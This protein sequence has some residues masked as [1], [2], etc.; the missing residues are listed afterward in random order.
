MSTSYTFQS[1]SVTLEKGAYR[2]RAPRSTRARPVSFTFSQ[3]ATS[4]KQPSLHSPN[5]KLVVLV[6]VL[7]FA[8][9]MCFFIAYY[10]FMTRFAPSFTCSLPVDNVPK[11][12]P[13]LPVAHDSDAQSKYLAYF[14]YVTQSTQPYSACLLVPP[15][16]LGKAIRYISLK[17][18]IILL[19]SALRSGLRAACWYL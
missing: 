13:F 4:A 15:P 19:H 3:G 18:S 9:V 7:A 1:P 10:L 11:A 8:S 12:N 6:C 14:P 2:M 17:S 5:R 16:H